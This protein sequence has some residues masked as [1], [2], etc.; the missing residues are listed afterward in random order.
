[1]RQELNRAANTS[2]RSGSSKWLS[3]RLWCGI[4][5]AFV[6]VAIWLA[7]HP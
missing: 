5:L 6:L 2:P 3:P 4:V 1:V 7:M